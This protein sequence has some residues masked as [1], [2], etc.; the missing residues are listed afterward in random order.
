MSQYVTYSERYMDDTYEYRHVVLP[1]DLFKLMPRN[2]LLTEQEWRALGVQQSKGW[3]HY[4][5]FKPEPNVL[6]FRR[7]LPETEKNGK[8]SKQ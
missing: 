8:T 5:I 3:E 2:R 6:I 4:L 7:P 1:N